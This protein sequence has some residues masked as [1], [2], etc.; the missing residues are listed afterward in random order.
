LPLLVGAPQ[1]KVKHL[2]IDTFATRLTV[3]PP[4]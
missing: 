1:D 4:I 3:L 2:K